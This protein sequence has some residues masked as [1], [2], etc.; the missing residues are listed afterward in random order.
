MTQLV[1]K[2]KRMILK[3]FPVYNRIYLSV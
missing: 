1:I 2:K 3:N